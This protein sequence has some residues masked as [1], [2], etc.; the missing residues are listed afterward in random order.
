MAPN[1]PGYI[2]SR[3]PGPVDFQPRPPEKRVHISIGEVGADTNFAPWIRLFSPT[4]AFLL[5]GYS[6][7][8]GKIDYDGI[9][10]TGTYTVVVA[11]SGRHLFRRRELPGDL[12]QVRALVVPANDDG[13]PMSKRGRVSGGDYPRRS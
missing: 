11:S 6:Q 7:L 3:R 13:G 1:H 4:G 2:L 9:P 10:T 5:E 12:G 8:G